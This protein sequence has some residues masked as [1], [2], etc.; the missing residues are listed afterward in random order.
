MWYKQPSF[1]WTTSAVLLTIG[2]YLGLM[3]SILLSTAYWPWMITS[4]GGLTLVRVERVI[5]RLKEIE[6]THYSD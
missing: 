3:A 2:S 4:M 6:G 1:W 5:K